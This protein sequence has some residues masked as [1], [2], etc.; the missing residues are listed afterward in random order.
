MFKNVRAAIAARP[1]AALLVTTLL[2]SVFVV[3]SQADFVASD[4]LWYADIAHNMNRDPVGVFSSHE[5]HPFVMRV[6]LTIPLAIIYRF[7][8]VS[9]LTT[10]LPALL[11]A[12]GIIVVAYAAATTPRAK[13]LALLFSITCLPLLRHA[14]LLNV[15]LPCAALLGAS[16]LGLARRDT[17][18]GALWLVLG[19]VFW[20]LAFLVKETALWC[21]PVWA[22]AFVSDLRADG[23]ANACRRFAA[24]MLVGAVLAGL[25]LFGC[26]RVWGSPLA[27]FQGIQDLTYEHTWSLHGHP[28]S[29]WLA[30]LTWQP[31]L[32]LAKMFHVAL[33]PAVLSF[34][35]VPRPQR[36]WVFA[37]ASFTLLYW[38]GSASLSSYTPLPISERMVL[39]VLV[40]ILVVAAISSDV[41]W[42]RL[43]AWRFR[44][45]VTACFALILMLPAL[46]VI[47]GQMRRPR[48]ETKAFAALRHEVQNSPQQFVLVCGEPRCV[49]IASFYFGLEIPS[50]ISVVFAGDFARG[51][52]PTK[53]MKVRALVNLPRATGARR[54]D[55]SLDK[56][57]A[58]D[59]LR[60]P[61]IVW[62]RR[63]RLYD[64]GDG[65]QLWTALH[66]SS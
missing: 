32:M 17:N 16:V 61:S 40:P 27:R 56:T 26:A 50:N 51:P 54:T 47:Q 49:S 18:R 7:F 24:P 46:R 45:L 34:W 14:T 66:S 30:R 19:M 5:N 37:A 12:I 20:F 22:Y 60:L 25:Y 6:G 52:M 57:D 29:E 10:N 48:P 21:A 36:V 41:L 39:P 13:L 62:D 31:A 42:D 3:L 64:A 65:S 4:P 33:I 35:L 23:I 9:T 43:A 2:L 55:P 44:K 1:L 15:D 8:G 53:N 63:V 58:I 59:A 28:A 38:F 11:S